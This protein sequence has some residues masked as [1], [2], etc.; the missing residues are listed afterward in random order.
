MNSCA[1]VGGHN[2]GYDVDMTA[3]QIFDVTRNQF[4]TMLG[5]TAYRLLDTLP[6][7]RMFDGNSDVP[8]G[9]SLEKAAKGLDIKIPNKAK[10]HTALFDAQVTAEVMH[11]FRKVL[12]DLNIKELLNG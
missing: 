4:L 8:S 1:M 5:P 10:L 9:A 7:M 11:A 3:R 12:K 2:V 6:L